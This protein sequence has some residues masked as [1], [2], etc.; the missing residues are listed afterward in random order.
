MGLLVT[1]YLVLTNMSSAAQTFEARVFTAMDGWFYCCKLL[2]IGALF[3]FAYLL[4]LRKK[5]FSATMSIYTAARDHPRDTSKVRVS[6]CPSFNIIT[7][8]L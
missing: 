4:K 1:S 8:C 7:C 2:V 5:T 6:K 3:E